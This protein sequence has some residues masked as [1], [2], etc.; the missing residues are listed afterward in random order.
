MATTDQKFWNEFKFL[1]ENQSQCKNTYD[2][3]T[4]K[5]PIMKP[6]FQFITVAPSAEVIWNTLYDQD[7][8]PVGGY[9]TEEIRFYMFIVLTL[10]TN[11]K[12]AKELCN[13]YESRVNELHIAT[14]DLIDLPIGQSSRSL[15]I[16]PAD[17]PQW[18]QSE[19][20]VPYYMLKQLN[21]PHTSEVWYKLFKTEYPDSHVYAIREDNIP[22]SESITLY[23]LWYYGNDII[24]EKYN[25]IFKIDNKLDYK[26]ISTKEEIVKLLDEYLYNDLVNSQ[27]L[28]YDYSYKITIP[29]FILGAS[30]AS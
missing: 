17:L 10:R 25:D 9:T 12:A 22:I 5:E 4:Q 24:T 2:Q 15:R 20:Y 30:D 19:L 8:I 11:F 21:I 29:P 28:I 3:Y 26:C 1:A 18:V 16:P 7:I 14:R 23:K 13:S 27:T 6:L